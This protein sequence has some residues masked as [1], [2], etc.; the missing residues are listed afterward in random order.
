MTI[1]NLKQAYCK[2]D[3]DERFYQLDRPLIGITGGIAT[4]KSTCAKYIEELGYPLIDAD[5][6]VKVIYS[7][8]ETIQ[9][10]KE[11]NSS[12]VHDDLINFKLLR[13]DVFQDQ[14][15]KQ[16]VENYIY[17][18]L[19]STFSDAHQKLPQVGALFYDIPLLFEKNLQKQFDM[20]ICVYSNAKVQLERIVKRDGISEDEAQNILNAQMPI[21][22]KAKL[23]D[24]IIPNSSDLDGLYR[25]IDNL[26][27]DLKA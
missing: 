12:Y 8:K 17:Q 3:K 20:S 14:K 13:K 5:R 7:K 10:V 6:L 21:D 26:I 2:L 22:D 23:A 15:L 16:R 9:F 1:L 27:E 4:G 18:Q 24:R 19:P 11:L 25:E